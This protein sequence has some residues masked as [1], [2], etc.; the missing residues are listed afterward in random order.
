MERLLVC[1]REGVQIPV[2]KEHEAA[3]ERAD[4]PCLATCGREQTRAL[5]RRRWGL[6]TRRCRG[7]LLLLA[8]GQTEREDA[9]GVKQELEQDQLAWAKKKRRG[10]NV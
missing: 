2:F 9:Q 6:G 4:A 7:L 10:C 1:C 5:W 3:H 8:S